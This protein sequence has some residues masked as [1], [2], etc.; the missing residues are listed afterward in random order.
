MR[1]LPLDSRM[2]LSQKKIKWGLIAVLLFF[3]FFGL[4]N[5]LAYELMQKNLRIQ[6]QGIFYPSLTRFQFHLQNVQLVWK[7]KVKV[8]S[9]NFSVNYGRP[10][11]WRLNPVR[12][13]LSG[14]DAVIK[15]EGDW[16]RMQGSQEVKLKKLFA[17][18]V[19]DQQGL[20]EIYQITAESP[21]FNFHIRNREEKIP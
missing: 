18:V 12:V 1:Q 13:Q 3:S 6:P 19:L 10:F 7:D 5:R 21:S 16:A 11:F 15:L 20:H 17:D 2:V 14:E 9:G 4:S 8:L